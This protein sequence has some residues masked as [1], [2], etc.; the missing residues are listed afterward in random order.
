MGLN[1]WR[2]ELQLTNSKILV[3]GMHGTTDRSNLNRLALEGGVLNRDDF[4]C[5]VFVVQVVHLLHTGKKQER[6][7]GSGGEGGT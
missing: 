7:A 1:G 4:T 3:Q 5:L 2:E 6:D